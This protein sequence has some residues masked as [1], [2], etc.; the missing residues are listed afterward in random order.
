[1]AYDLMDLRRRIIAS[2]PNDITRE[3]SIVSFGT[4]IAR[5]MQVTCTLSP[6]QSGSGDPYPPG[7]GK[8][9]LDDSGLL[10]G[11]YDTTGRFT[12][13]NNY[14][15]YKV[16][17]PAGTYT[18][19]TDLANCFIPRYLI[20]DVQ[21]PASVTTQKITFTLNADGEFKITIRNTSTTSIASVTPHSQIESGFTDT[22]YSTYSNIRP[23]YGWT[24]C[25]VTGAGVNLWDK[26]SGNVLNMSIVNANVLSNSGNAKTVY[27][28]CKSNTTYTVS[29]NAGLR[30][31]VAYIKTEPA[32]NV[33]VYGR[34]VDNSGVTSL[35]ITTGDNAKY[36]VAY[37]FNSTYDTGTAQDMID[38]VQIEKG[39]TASTYSAYT[40]TTIPIVWQTTAGTVYGGTM[41]LNRD[42][43]VTVVATHKRVDLG[44]L[45][46]TKVS[47]R[48][49]G[50]ATVSD[51]ETTGSAEK[52]D[53][54]CDSYKSATWDDNV[55]AICH[56]NAIIRISNPA[57]ADMTGT[58]IGTALDGVYAVYPL[59][60]PLTY[61]LSASV[62]NS[63]AG[64][65]NV[66]ADAG[67]V[68]VKA[69]GF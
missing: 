27:I 65:N 2:Q 37:I 22:A 39:S 29:K 67:D 35:T 17:L 28:P 11:Y 10:R 47:N 15:S 30:F 62:L 9:K 14:I 58:Q 5:P 55:C 21:T 56:F 33:P 45:S 20:D 18:F 50:Y 24:G 44:S 63:L 3:G 48:S 69:W 23:I 40:G 53:I 12:S 51:M 1:M 61:T 57:F 46:W 32:N 43:S 68:S 59:A 41:T 60:T 13:N 8:N 66:W 64:Q 26:T 16:S 34:I 36:L 6:V 25:D 52:Y 49:R 38:S 19:S 54:I 4:N 42:G 31:T 7:G